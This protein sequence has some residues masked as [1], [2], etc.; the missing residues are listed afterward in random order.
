MINKITD[1]RSRTI[2]PSAPPFRKFDTS[3][4]EMSEKHHE[5]ARLLVLGQK[6]KDISRKLAISDSHVYN[7]RNSPIVRE[8]MAFLMGSRDAETVQISERI[9]EALPDCIEFLA[10]TIKDEAISSTLK[11][12]N[13]FGLLA[14]GGHGITKNVNVRGVHAILTPAD[15]AEIRRHAEDIG[16]SEG[17]AKVKCQKEADAR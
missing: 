5:I 4:Q 16:F 1:I 7:V 14:I 3:I 9:Q 15:I 12:K 8:Q 10:E 6:P 17:I 2:Q 11:S 13:A